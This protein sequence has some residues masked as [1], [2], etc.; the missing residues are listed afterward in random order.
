MQK[1][2]NK[3]D[4]KRKRIE[5]RK[6]VKNGKV[7]VAV[8]FSVQSSLLRPNRLDC[9]VKSEI[10][11]RVLF[12]QNF[13]YANMR[14]FMKNKILV[15]WRNYS[16]HLLMKANHAIVANFYVANMSFNAFLENKILTKISELTVPNENML[17]LLIFSC[18]TLIL[19][20]LVSVLSSPQKYS[21]AHVLRCCAHC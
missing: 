9:T 5:R 11:M 8:L 17:C 14:S 19:N 15:K 18:K 10:F 3:K 7:R 12:S 4:R 16:Y 6:G 2:N 13:A 21:F 20:K 1:K